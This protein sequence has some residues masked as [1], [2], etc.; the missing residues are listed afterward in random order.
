LKTGAD[1]IS[2]MVIHGSNVFVAKTGA[3]GV[4]LGKGAML[5]EERDIGP[6]AN[7]LEWKTGANVVRDLVTGANV[8]E[9]KTGADEVGDLVTGANVFELKTGED[10]DGDLV[11]GTSVLESVCYQISNKSFNVSNIGYQTR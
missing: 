7:E 6:E 1:V 4:E 10:V 5:V 9:S 8:L 11:T 3:D 2:G